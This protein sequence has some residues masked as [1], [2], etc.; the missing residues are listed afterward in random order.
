MAFKNTNLIV[1][2]ISK[3]YERKLRQEAAGSIYVCNYQYRNKSDIF[4]TLSCEKQTWAFMIHKQINFLLLESTRTTYNFYI[5]LGDFSKRC[6]F[7]VA[8]QVVVSYGI[9]D[10]IKDI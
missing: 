6:Q 7:E 5:F 9:N 8:F 1:V 10:I 3:S 2:T 4:T